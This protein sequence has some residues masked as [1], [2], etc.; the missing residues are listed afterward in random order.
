[1]HRRTPGP[2]TPA[3]ILIRWSLQRGLIVLPKSTHRDR[4]AQN[5]EVFDFELSAAEMTA[6]DALDRT[7]GTD[8]A[9]ETT[10]W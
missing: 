6:L 2:R 5:A 7:E 9:L 10:W 4:I 1:M 3:Q 8:R